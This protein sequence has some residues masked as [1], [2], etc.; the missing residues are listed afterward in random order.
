[1]SEW[2]AAHLYVSV[3]SLVYFVLASFDYQHTVRLS[4][5][6]R[7][8]LLHITSMKTWG[9]RHTSVTKE[10]AARGH[11]IMCSVHVQW[12]MSQVG[13]V[14][15]QPLHLVV[16]LNVASVHVRMS[17]GSLS[18]KPV[19]HPFSINALLFISFLL[20]SLSKCNFFF[21]RLPLFLS[22]HRIQPFFGH[23]LLVAI[24]CF[25]VPFL[26]PPDSVLFGLICPPAPLCTCS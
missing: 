11:R 1:M 17:A 15:Y 18:H 2:L 14:S 13:E 26:V 5:R 4:S 10:I 3:V 9:E 24:S 7:M 20:L 6:A 23:L 16:F 25:K 12:T 21:R 22:L 19:F 8:P